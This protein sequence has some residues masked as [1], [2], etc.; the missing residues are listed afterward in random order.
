M[1]KNTRKVL[2]SLLLVPI[3][4][5][6]SCKN[7][8]DMDNIVFTEKNVVQQSFGGLGVE[9]GAYE[10]VD[11]ITPNSWDRILKNMD[12][13]GA[14]R[15]RLMIS[16]D[17]I[18]YN[19][20]NKGTTDKNDDTW[21][22][23]FANKWAK[24]TIDILTYCQEHNIDVAFG[25]WNV[26]A[27][28][29]NDVWGMLDDVS[30]D[31][32][33]AKITSDVLDFLVNK[34]GFT[35]I[36]WF[37]NTN[38]PNYTGLV[39][40]SKN[41]LNTYEKWEQGVKNVRAALDK[42]GLKDISIVGGDVTMTSDNSWL[43][44]LLNISKNIPD[45]VGDY[46]MHAY[47]KNR[48][49]DQGEMMTEIQKVTDQIKK[50]DKGYGTERFANI[51]EGGLYDGKNNE[52]DCQLAIRTGLYGVR[53]ADYTMQSLLAGVNGICY[54]DFDD[55]MHFMYNSE[56]P[57]PKEWG[58]FSSL[59]GVSAEK[60]ELRPW[61]HSSV[62]LTQMLKKGNKIYGSDTNNP[63]LDKTFRCLGTTNQDNTQAGFMCVNQGTKAVEKTF[64]FDN[65]IEGE[66][67]YIYQFSD[68]NYKLDEEGFIAPNYVIDGSLNK[69]LKL[70]INAHELMVVSTEKL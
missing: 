16:Y 31:I 2:S 20:D 66:K 38:E 53:M 15:I 6:S 4:I 17:W 27:N 50:N 51:W 14:S 11:K 33:W 54:W 47:I 26:I 57:T 44:Y 64:R 32:R 28:M 5:L 24:N 56:I 70:T 12:R 65:K 18:C 45:K 58:M 68:K 42:A 40:S 46:G 13:L 67:L 41:A 23:N 37:V 3:G 43:D 8:V 60:Q 10:D 25:A 19:F 61:Y 34:K 52:T 7:T 21:T 22:Y 69:Q 35:C 30:S 55:G 63:E 62:L 59:E 9:W 39:G 1:R 48:M 29:Q 36:K 49:L